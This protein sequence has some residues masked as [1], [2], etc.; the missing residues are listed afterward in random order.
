MLQ[1]LMYYAQGYH[2]AQHGVP[3]FDSTIE[4]WKDGPVVRDVYHQYKEHGA[5]GIPCL[6]EPRLRRFQEKHLQVMNDVFSE[7]GQFSASTLRNMTHGE[8]PWK[9]TKDRAVISISAIKNYFLTRVS[10]RNV[11]VSAD[12]RSWTEIADVILKQRRE[13]W[14]ELARM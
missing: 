12:K 13:L 9:E 1:K 7:F 3:L 2:L 5:G 6:R 4:A 8:P 14:Q 10:L 11:I